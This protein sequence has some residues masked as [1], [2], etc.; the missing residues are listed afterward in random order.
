M[1]ENFVR[2][3]IVE[4]GSSDLRNYSHVT[5]WADRGNATAIEGVPGV[6]KVDANDI[7][8]SVYIDPRYDLQS[9]L[10]RIREILGG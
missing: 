1:N 8:Y 10:A 5:V 2:V 9:V 6:Y 3:L 4:D 7:R